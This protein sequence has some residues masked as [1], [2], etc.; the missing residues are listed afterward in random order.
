MTETHDSIPL[1]T[2]SEGR[3]YSAGTYLDTHF[4]AAREEYEAMA[5]SAGFQP[6]WTILDAGAGDCYA[7]SK[8]GRFSVRKRPRSTN[9]FIGNLLIFQ[10]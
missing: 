10:T 5:H 9:T 8:N 4:A 3:A 6:G 7:G 2:T 1:T